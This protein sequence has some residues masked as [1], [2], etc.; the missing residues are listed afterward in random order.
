MTLGFPAP[1][2]RR[3]APGGGGRALLSSC[4]SP[5]V[6]NV[7]PGPPTPCPSTRFQPSLVENRKG[8]LKWHWVTV[9]GS[10]PV[11]MG[12]AQEWAP[13][14]LEVGPALSWPPARPTPL[15]DFC[16]FRLRGLR[17]AML[18]I[19]LALPP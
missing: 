18:A 3:A 12:C 7:T 17:R 2:S 11:S 4:K 1:P 9:G 13:R 6:T 15:P 10:V 16:Q 5:G 14:H 8:V 19:R